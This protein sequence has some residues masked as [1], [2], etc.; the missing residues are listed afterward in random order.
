MTEQ[1][2]NKSGA[3]FAEC[4]A[5]MQQCCPAAGK[6]SKVDFSCCEAMMKSFL[7]SKEG[8]VNLD[9]VKS[10]M[11]MCCG[12]SKKDTTTASQN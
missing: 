5:R 9:A 8:N 12:G 6:D 1:K 3:G 10:M 4:F 2:E 11:A 7:G